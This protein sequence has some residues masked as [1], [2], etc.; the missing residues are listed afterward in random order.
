MIQLVRI[1]RQVEATNFASIG[2]FYNGHFLFSRR[3]RQFSF[4]KVIGRKTPDRTSFLANQICLV[5]FGLLRCSLTD[6][7]D[8]FSPS[9]FPSLSHERAARA[10]NCPSC[11]SRLPASLLRR[12]RVPGQLERVAPLLLLNMLLLSMLLLKLLLLKLL[13]LNSSLSTSELGENFRP[14]S[15]LVASRSTLSL[16]NRNTRPIAGKDHVAAP[17]DG[18]SAPNALS[19]SCFSNVLHQP[20]EK[21]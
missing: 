7:D 19:S 4:G 2:N 14:F 3:S 8:F 9:A 10:K 20:F 11:C 16:D 5:V 13:L 6:L 12:G 18:G 21:K 15:I 17:L 1:L